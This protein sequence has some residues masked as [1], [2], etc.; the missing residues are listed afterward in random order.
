MVGT[1]GW[2]NGDACDVP[3]NVQ[4]GGLHDFGPAV[5]FDSAHAEQ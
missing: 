3:Q 2:N 5:A 4:G 1:V